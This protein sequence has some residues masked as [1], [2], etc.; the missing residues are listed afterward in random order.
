MPLSHDHQ[1]GLVVA[2]HLRRAV[3]EDERLDAAEEFVRFVDGPGGE[4]FREE[5][6][7]LFPLVAAA[8]DDSPL[9]ERATRDHVH[10]RA[11]AV[12]LRHTPDPSPEALQTLGGRLDAHIRLEERELFPLAERIVSERDLEAMQLPERVPSAA[13]IDATPLDGPGR[14]TVWSIAS[15]DLNATVLAWPAGEGVADHTNRER[16]VLLVVVGGGGTLVIDGRSHAL[17][18]PELVLIPRGA[19]RG[20]TAGAD[21]LR[22]VSVHLRRRGLVELRR[23]PAG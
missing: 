22:Y 11:A 10:F 1:H 9:V 5:E 4:H 7:V 19:S 14:G 8:L 2:R 23:R 16:D 18:A 20:I 12:R 13:K 3:T 6:D 21:G 17:R 15:A